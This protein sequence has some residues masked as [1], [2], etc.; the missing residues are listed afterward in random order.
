MYLLFF[1]SAESRLNCEMC[2]IMFSLEDQYLFLVLISKKDVWQINSSTNCCMWRNYFNCGETSIRKIVLFPSCFSRLC[3]KKFREKAA[4]K[5]RHVFMILIFIFN[6]W[7][8]A[9]LFCFFHLFFILFL[10]TCMFTLIMCRCV[11]LC[12]YTYSYL[13][14]QTWAR[15]CFWL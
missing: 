1:L 5:S 6:Y 7:S 9:S 11:Y 4:K 3:V 8:D 2:E 15:V 12:E 13:L 14:I 10:G